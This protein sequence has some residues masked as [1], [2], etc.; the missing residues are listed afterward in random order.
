[1]SAKNV[2]ISSLPTINGGKFQTLGIVSDFSYTS[3]LQRCLNFLKTRGNELGADAVIGTSCFSRSN[4]GY[5]YCYGTA[6]KT[7]ND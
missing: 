2:I 7:L 3:D 5:M 6:V 1:M 4:T